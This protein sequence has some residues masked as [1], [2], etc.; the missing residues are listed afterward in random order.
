MG[1]GYDK[2]NS[3]ISRTFM[4]NEPQINKRIAKN[5]VLLN[6]RMVFV[7]CLNLYTTRVT[8]RALGVED[9]GIYNVVCGFVSMFTF[10]NTSM[11]NGIQRFFNFELGKRGVDGARKV[12]VTSLAVQMLLL[13]AVLLLAETLG[14]WYL[15]NKLVIPFERF[16]AAQWIF[17]FSIVSFMFIIMQ[18]PYNAAIMA[19]ERMNYYA[20]I[21][22][23]D[24]LLKLIIVFLIPFAN[25]D[26]LI[27][28]GFLLTIISLLNLL[29]AYL[30][31]RMQFEEVRLRP[32]FDKE[33]F[34]SMLFFSGWNV[35]GTFSGMMREQGLN[36]LLN[37]FFGSVVNAARGIAYQVST[38]LQGFVANVSIAIRP[39]IV[40]SYA[41][42]N[43][44][45]TINLMHCLSKVSV[46]LLYIIGYP[47]LLE[48]DYV[49][50][51]W[52]GNDVPDYTASFVVIVV[53]I[54]FLNNMNSAV[55]VVVHSTGEMRNYQLIT[56]LITLLSLPIAYY[57]LKQGGSP[58][59][60][61][62]ISFAFTALM[63]FASL[64]VL[65]NLLSFS[66]FRYFNQVIL[67]FSYILISSF[68]IPLIPHH[69]MQYGGERFIV[70][71]FLAIMTSSVSTY[72][73]G[74][75]KK[76]KLLIN[77]IIAKHI[78]FLGG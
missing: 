12:Y 9:F 38:G 73:L 6:I 23:F 19:H 58:K 40:Q 48:I 4:Q 74:L 47:V 61:F 64:C 22:V 29:L 25:V 57:V 51:L 32:M 35:F 13:F 43:I 71:S 2:G 41:Q 8:L 53:L 52:L 56:S 55:S 76:E 24:A 20:F 65:R 34:K 36:M 77:S 18:V 28:Y 78:P 68:A 33:M 16:V 11:S 14:L 66:L 59:S 49:L 31:S 75:N 72:V 54:S 46:S 26:K 44:N 17:Q 15:H 37:F 45:R 60:V 69:I 42:G 63:Q 21:S 30:Y 70:V 50:S 10:L 3:I 67:P 39:Q 62:W 1:G 5:A 27:L 7:L